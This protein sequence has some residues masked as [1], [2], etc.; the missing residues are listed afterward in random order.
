MPA[1]IASGN[2]GHPATTADK[3]RLNQGSVRCAHYTGTL[4]ARPEVGAPDI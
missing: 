2:A 1:R 4:K 3:S